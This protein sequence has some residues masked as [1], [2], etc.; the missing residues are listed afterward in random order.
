VAERRQFS[1]CVVDDLLVGIPVEDVQEVT[2]GLELTPVP[3]APPVIGGLLNLRGEIVT[4]IDLRR[5]LQ[6]GARKADQPP[7]SLIL[8]ADEGCISLLVDQVGDVLEIDE[9]DFEVPPRTF[10]GRLRELIPGTYKLTDRLLLVLDTERVLRLVND[11]QER[12]VTGGV[13]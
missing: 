8:R 5:C 4:A 6:L 9:V 10:R 12:V 2:S 7:V 13:R 11:E 1:S 3:L